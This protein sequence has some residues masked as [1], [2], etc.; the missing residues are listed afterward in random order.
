[1]CVCVCV[2]AIDALAAS[3]SET[4]AVGSDRD[5]SERSAN[6]QMECEG[7]GSPMQHT[8][9]Q[10]GAENA[11]KRTDTDTDTRTHTRTH[12][13]AHTCAAIK[14]EDGTTWGSLVGPEALNLLRQFIVKRLQV[15]NFVLSHG[16]VVLRIRQLFLQPEEHTRTHRHIHTH[17]QEHV[18]WYSEVAATL[19]TQKQA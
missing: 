7:H 13:R 1:M 14:S 18:Y 11:E 9:N 19:K 3:D 8:R 6:A 15:K 10:K 16:A 4:A 12:P 2:C 17:T 5:D